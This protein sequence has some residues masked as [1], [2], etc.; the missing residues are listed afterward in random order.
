MDGK[1]R[2]PGQILLRELLR[3]VGVR[4]GSLQEQPQECTAPKEWFA[5]R[6]NHISRENR[7]KK[8]TGEVRYW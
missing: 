6:Y 2:Q 3:E 1:P 7:K 5:E 8:K 4:D